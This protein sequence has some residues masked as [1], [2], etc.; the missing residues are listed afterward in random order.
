[1]P[2]NRFRC[3]LRI[4]PEPPHGGGLSGC[5]C[6]EGVSGGRFLPPSKGGRYAEV[7]AD[8]TITGPVIVEAVAERLDKA[9]IEAR[10]PAPAP[11]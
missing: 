7:F 10:S 3:G 2:L 1:V 4:C 9:G 6:S 11:P 5:T 8:A